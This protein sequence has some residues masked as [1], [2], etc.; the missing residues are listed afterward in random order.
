MHLTVFQSIFLFH[1][2]FSQAVSSSNNVYER[3]SYNNQL[4][5][6]YQ[7]F[8]NIAIL[9]MWGYY[10]KF[11]YTKWFGLYYWYVKI[12]QC[13]YVQHGLQYITFYVQKH[14]ATMCFNP[15][16]VHIKPLG[17]PAFV[18]LVYRHH[19]LGSVSCSTNNYT[20]MSNRVRKYIYC[21]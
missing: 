15:P 2:H 7:Y 13:G 12:P 11:D 10:N 16:L 6:A 17:S 3:I 14:I 4:P 20:T 9:K 19:P 1:N 5:V 18:K 8:T 21:V